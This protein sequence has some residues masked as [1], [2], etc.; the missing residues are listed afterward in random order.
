MST[1]TATE[2]EVVIG[3]EVHVQL[4]TRSK[5]FASAPN[6]FGDEPNANTTAVCMALPGVLPVLNEAAV[7][8][9]VRLG[10]ALNCEI[11]HYTKFDRKQYF[12]PDLPKAYQISQYDKPI[13]LNGSLTLPSG[14]VVGIERAHLEEDAGKLVHQGADGLAGST[15]SLVDLNRAGTP[16]LEIVSRPDLRSA[17]EAKEYVTLLRNM[18]RYLGVCDGNLE[19]GSL[20]CD[21][22]VSLRPKGSDTLG[23]RTETKNM[24]S[25]RAIER[26]I[27]SEVERQKT[28]LEAGGTIIQETR[29]WN[30]ATGETLPMRGKEHAHDY[31]YFPEPDLPPL[32]ISAVWLD[33]VK[34][35]Q[36]ETPAQRTERLKTEFGLSDY[37]AEVM[38]EFKEMGDLFLAATAKTSA[39]KV[40]SNLIQS[41]IT[42]WLKAEGKKLEETQLTPEALGELATLFESKAVSSSIVKKL[43]P[44]LLTEGGEPKAQMERLGL[45]Q[46]S[47]ESALQSAIDKI[48]AE[49]QNQVEAYRGGKTKLMGFFVG[50][51]MKETKGQANPEVVNKLLK[52]SLDG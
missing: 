47:D 12:Y 52:S 13:C 10:L 24:N 35:T 16:L 7:E 39:Y 40:L 19:E 25:F 23:T 17:E 3:L 21:A 33:K 36:P 15:H 31:R 5:L 44:V 34:Q 22:N 29:L 18:V 9:A 51:V 46:I 11:A 20:R 4:N 14:R 1:A 2:W 45:V 26:A 30:D 8:K 37:D 48:I 27:L 49:N 32:R 28:I 43:L 38:T 42:G 6:N 50:Q 41:E